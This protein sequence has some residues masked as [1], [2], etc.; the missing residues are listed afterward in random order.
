MLRPDTLALTAL[1]ALLTGIGPLSTDMYLPSMPDIG[2]LLNAPPAYVQLTLSSYL[3]GFACGQIF[4]GPI[5]D[6]HGRKPVLLAALILFVLA[7]AACSFTTSIGTLITARAFQAFG[8]SG[9]IVLAR[10]IVRDLYSGS[11]AGRELSLMGAIMALAP[12]AAPVIGG[13]LQTAF[14]WRANFIVLIAVG[15]GLAAAVWWLLPETLRVRAP[16][17]VSLRSTLKGFAAIARHRAYLAY[18]GMVTAS[19]A[20]L[21]AWISGASF[22]LQQLYG[23]SPFTFGVAFAL[24]SVGYLVGT[25]LATRVVHRI[26]IGK[27]IGW[28][29]VAVAIGG[30]AMV[31]AVAFG[32]RSAVSLILPV[33]LY[34]AGIGLVLPQ[35]MAGALTPFPNRAGAASSLLGFVQQS[36]AAI[37]GAAIGFGLGDSAW[38][39]A[40]GIA[41]MGCLT[42]AIWFFT[43]GLRAS[44]PHLHH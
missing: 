38:P 14:G 12:V 30:L 42:F 28:G 20:G 32:L 5:S 35:S 7:S 22:V 41:L 34:L 26:G 18:L 23:L 16:E 37:L 8:G 17:P 43:R 13:V 29:A 11:R 36:A 24:G 40:A 27:T 25:A 9:A 2:L 10:A 33:S 19:Y 4:Y 1:L 15:C 31:I 6:R 44:D 3:I 21:F 39:M